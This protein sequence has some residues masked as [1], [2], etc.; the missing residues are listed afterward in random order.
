MKLT[1]AAS[2]QSCNCGLGCSTGKPDRRADGASRENNWGAPD[3][4]ETSF[5]YVV[6]RLMCTIR[7][8]GSRSSTMTVR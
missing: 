8:F 7:V 6:F 2:T 3:P 1:L 5:N 4:A